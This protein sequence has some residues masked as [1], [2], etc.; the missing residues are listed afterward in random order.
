M[1][2]VTTTQLPLAIGLGLRT[3]H[4]KAVFQTQPDVAWFEVHSE[5]FFGGGQNRALLQRIRKNYPISLH[6]VGLG[7]GAAAPLDA[8]HLAALVQL[9]A[10]IDPAAVSEHLCWNRLPG[11]YFND[12][13]PMPYTEEA[14]DLLT[15][16]IHFVQDQ[17]KRPLLIENVS[18][19]IAFAGAEMSE[20]DMLS[21]LSKRTACGILLDVNNVYVNHINLGIDP[22]TFF[23]ALPI[24]SVQEIHVAGFS[25]AEGFLLDTHSAP[26][27]APVWGLLAKAYQ[28]FGPQPT[29]VE[30]DTDIPSFEVLQAEGHRAAQVLSTFTESHP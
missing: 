21:M 17:L 28:R 12:L 1:S 13:L 29:L 7:L 4:W 2:H 19:S 20:A 22:D 16:R 23:A 26:V 6:G 10:E 9:V 27:A 15:S 3:P 14:V 25:Q 18:T 11:Q 24:H 30:W 8:H 5:N